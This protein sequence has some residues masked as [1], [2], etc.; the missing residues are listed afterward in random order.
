M[1]RQRCD[2]AAFFIFSPPP[3]FFFVPPRLTFVQT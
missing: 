2:N 1:S 3:N